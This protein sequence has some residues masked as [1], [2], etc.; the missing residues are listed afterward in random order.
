MEIEAVLPT[1][2][3]RC[4]LKLNPESSSIAAFHGEAITVIGGSEPRGSAVV[5]VVS[6]FD[7]DDAWFCACVIPCVGSSGGESCGDVAINDG[8]IDAS[9]GDGLGCI[10]VARCECQR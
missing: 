9:D 10:P 8:V 1:G 2:C 3:S 5:I 4:A 6:I 7:G